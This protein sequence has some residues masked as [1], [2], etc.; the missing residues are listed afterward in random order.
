MLLLAGGCEPQDLRLG[1]SPGDRPSDRS[2]LEWVGGVEEETEPEPEEEPGEAFFH[3][4]RV[5]ALGLAIDS[6]S[7]QALLQ[8][9]RDY[10]PVTLVVGDDTYEVGVRLKGGSTYRQLSDKPSLKVKFDFVVEDQRIWG[11]QGINLH[12]QT[13]DP[14]MLAEG[15]AY[16]VYRRLGVAAPRTAF[17]SLT[18]N[19]LDYG[20]YAA[21]ERKDKTWLRRWF[22][23]DEGTLYETGSFNYPCDFDDAGGWG[24]D[25]CD[26]WEVDE[27]GS[28]DT[29]DDLV[30]LCEAVVA[31]PP[32]W[33]SGLQ[34]HLDWE[35]WLR[36]MATDMLI[37]H[38][39]GYGY[40]LNNTH[41][42]HDPDTDSWT[43]SPW[44]TDLAFGW[45][46][47]SAQQGCGYLGRD[48][49]DYRSGYLVRRC[50]DD[51]TCRAALEQEVLV[52][53]GELEAMD[54]PSRLDDL[55][56]V[57][58]VPVT[59]DPRR[60]YSDGDFFEQVACIQEWIGRRPAYLEQH[61]DGE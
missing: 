13:Y 10:A 56:S 27:V 12:N 37:S 47:W 61:V 20:F 46:P 24:A 23:S 9:P 35:L 8:A 41:I 1:P 58:Q 15:L 32:G 5:H 11:L 31:G 3:L 30:A 40:N 22:E 18:V 53:A 60:W 45:Y 50:Q 59:Q 4:D 16:E 21:V 52:L 38:W 34:E 48:V 39:D 51:S 17:V 54:L 2:G 42:Y 26:C 29:R 14:S 25:P 44:S 55:V 36:S 33:V 43:F 19:D 28:E 49:G 7:W 57:I 6:Q